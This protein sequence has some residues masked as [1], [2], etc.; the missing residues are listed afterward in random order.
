MTWRDQAACKSH[1]PAWWFAYQIGRQG[2][3][4]IHTKESQL[5]IGICD[6]CPVLE[7]CYEFAMAYPSQTLNGIWGGLT[8]GERNTHRKAAR[9]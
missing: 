8:S 3:G 6:D 2:G 4:T 9:S 5:A 1:D 7:D